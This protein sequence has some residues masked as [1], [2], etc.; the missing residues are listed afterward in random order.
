MQRRNESLEEAT[1]LRRL[2]MEKL[3]RREKHLQGKRLLRM[4]FVL[5]IKT[6]KTLIF[7]LRRRDYGGE[8][9]LIL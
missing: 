5:F 7:L 2:A 3:M 9:G 8:I 1:I 6:E 4:G